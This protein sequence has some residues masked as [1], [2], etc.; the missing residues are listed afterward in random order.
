LKGPKVENMSAETTGLEKAS[1][2]MKDHS[3]SLLR[4]LQGAACTVIVLWGVRAFSELLGPLLLA[5]MLSYGAVA[6][7]KWLMLRFK[8]S[9]G[10]AISLTAMALAA[11]G[12]FVIVTLEVGLA[13]LAARLPLYAQRLGSLGEQVTALLAAHG[14][15]SLNFSAQN[16]LTPERLGPIAALVVPAA[17]V[18][19]M[20][21]LLIFL[22]AFLFVLEMLRDARGNPSLIGGILSRHGLYSKRYLAVTI[23]SGGINS[24]LN[25]VLLVT[26]GVDQALLWTLL[27]FFLNFIPTVGFSMALIPPTVVTLLMHGWTWALVVAGGLILTNLFVDNVVTPFFA[28]RALHISF[29]ELTLSLVGWSFLLGVAGAII[30]IPLTLALKDQFKHLSGGT[31]HAEK[32]GS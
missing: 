15:H 26:L 11:A 30:A 27:Y 10:R 12:L 9:Q 4:F 6:L 16:A 7:P 19:A 28:K 21:V 5:L 1:G 29:L 18:V 24:V 20:E 2:R 23:K 14:V 13:Q 22:L 31:N 3:H 25:L 17:G 8:L 32:P